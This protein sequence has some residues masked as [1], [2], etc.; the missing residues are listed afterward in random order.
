MT[1]GDRTSC[2]GAPSPHALS[3]RLLEYSRSRGFPQDGT[4]TIQLVLG[5]SESD[6]RDSAGGGGANC[7]KEEWED[8]SDKEC[9]ATR[10]RRKTPSYT[11]NRFRLC[12]SLHFSKY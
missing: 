8:S 9:S 1:P 4:G 6:L 5:L 2:L 3:Q 12:H 7:L 11:P 10:T